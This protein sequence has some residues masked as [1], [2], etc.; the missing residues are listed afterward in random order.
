M[1]ATD[2]L[3]GSARFLASGVNYAFATLLLG[4][5]FC[6]GAR[7]PQRGPDLREQR[8]DVLWLLRCSLALGLCVGLA[9][10]GK[11]GPVWRGH[12]RFPSG[13]AAFAAAAATCLIRRDHRRW[14]SLSALLVTL[15]C[16]ALVRARYHDGPDVAGALL[17]APTITLAVLNAAPLQGGPQAGLEGQGAQGDG[18]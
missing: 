16:W 5:A 7:P 18:A 8:A 14:A 17:L 15:L 10:A 4:A 1:D 13:H 11:A 9:K 6:P 3:D 12:P 2:A